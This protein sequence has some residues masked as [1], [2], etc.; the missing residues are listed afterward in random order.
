MSDVHL[1]YFDFLLSELAKNNRAVETSFGRHVHWGYWAEPAAATYDDE[2][3]AKAA[4]RLTLELCALAGIAEGEKILDVGCGFG[5]AIASLNERFS[6][7]DMTG[8]NIDARQLA[9]AREIV[10]PLKN[11]RIDFV[12]GDACRLPFADASFD[13]LLAIEC[14]FHFPSREAFFREA[15]RV[16]KPGGVLALSDFVPSRAFLPVCM[17]GALPW[18][19]NMNAVGSWNVRCTLARYRDLAASTGFAPLAERDATR[20]TLPTYAYLQKM[21]ERGGGGGLFAKLLGLNR[22][23]GA[24]G[25]LNYYLLSFRRP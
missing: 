5:G 12:E 1:P 17:F 8:L 16:L 11:N 19:R 25:L 4:E 20:N 7:L 24:L 3:Y 13:R 18:F 21:L 6:R 10:Q 22:A 2:D 9:R 14:I 23:L 15:F